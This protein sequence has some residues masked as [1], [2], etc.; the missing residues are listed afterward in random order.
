MAGRPLE[1]S[2]DLL[3]HVSDTNSHLF[4]KRYLKRDIQQGE[5]KKRYPY[6]CA[7]SDYGGNS[8]IELLN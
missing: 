1:N 7:Q 2:H 3:W 4:L 6:A 5:V 8:I